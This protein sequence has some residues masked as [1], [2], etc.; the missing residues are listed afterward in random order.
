MTRPT[1]LHL[2]SGS[3]GGALG[4]HRAGFRGVGALDFNE[5][6]CRDLA[7]FTGESAHHVDIAAME[8]PAAL[9]NLCAESPDVVFASPPC[10]GFSGCL[11]EQSAKLD[12]Y[13]RLNSLAFHGIWL[14]L[15][16]WKRPPRLVLLE[17]VPRIQSRGRA[18]LERIV[19]LLHSYGYAVNTS[20][21]DCGELGGLAQRRRRFLLVARHMPQVE[22]F[23]RLPSQK[24]VKTIGEVLGCLPVPAPGAKSGGAMHA[25]PR[26]SALNWVRLALIPAGRDWRA[27]PDSV[28]LTE[29]SGRPNGPYGVESWEGPSH[30]V[31]GHTTARD[32]WGSVADPRVGCKRREGGHGVR[33]WDG[34]SA[35]VIGHPSIDNFP[36]QVADPRLSHNPHRGCVGVARWDRESR[37]IRGAHNINNATASLADPRTVKPTHRVGPG[38]PAN[39]V[40]PR[41]DLEGRRPCHVV[42]AAA[43]RTWHRPMTTLEL[44]ALQGF[45]TEIDGEPLVLD[46][47][48]HAGWRER[49]GNAVPPPTA[50]AIALSCAATLEAAAAGRWTLDGNPIWV[51]EQLRR[52]SG[53][54]WSEVAA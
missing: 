17:N 10:K 5:A 1:V 14:A 26:L 11:P 35:A 31:L 18:W 27:I 29:R 32:T 36:A 23:L 51:R 53:R 38:E 3:G 52:R 50:Y 8:T 12:K 37:T 22:A 19:A 2:F 15:E 25:L 6:A 43:D 13:Q 30:A 40:G 24:P 46:G 49:I 4:F 39:I 21:H 7:R 45:P 20:V 16:A 44:A 9:A 54:A 47:K 34:Q 41:L 48:S 33:P 42:I 28:R